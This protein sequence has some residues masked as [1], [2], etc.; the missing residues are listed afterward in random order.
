[1]AEVLDRVDGRGPPGRH[2]ELLGA[3]QHVDVA[4]QLGP[5]LDAQDGV[6]V[7]VR[8]VQ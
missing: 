2:P 6:E 4:A 7:G 3:E 5:D 1:V 8:L